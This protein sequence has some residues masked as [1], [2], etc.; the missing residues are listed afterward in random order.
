[1]DIVSLLNNLYYIISVISLLGIIAYIL[2]KRS[3]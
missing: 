2:I 3:E 1:M